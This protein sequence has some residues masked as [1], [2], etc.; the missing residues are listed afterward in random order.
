ML[1]YDLPINTHLL[2]AAGSLGFAPDPDGP[3]ELTRLGAFITNPVSLAPRAPAH[4]PR[5]LPFPGGL[6]LHTG[7]PNPGLK[8]VLRRAAARWSRSPAPVWAH[9]LGGG[10][11]EVAEIVR[12]LE[13]VEGVTGIELGLPPGVDMEAALRFVRSAAGELPFVGA[14]AVRAGGRAGGGLAGSQRE[15]WGRDRRLQP[16]PPGALPGPDAG[17]FTGGCMARPS[18]PGAGGRQALARLV[19]VIGSGG[20]YRPRDVEAMLAAGAV[21]VQPRFGAVER[22]LEEESG[23]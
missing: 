9:I 4:G 21:A 6:L 12:Q 10:L 20:L 13:K 2:N 3:V 16:G 17:W 1:K 14:A 18:C 5:L 11:D 19:S 8:A 7:H 15:R 22:G 23:E